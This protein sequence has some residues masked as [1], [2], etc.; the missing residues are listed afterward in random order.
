MV[1]SKVFVPVGAAGGRGTWPI[2]K[3]TNLSG[4]FLSIK[5]YTI[6]LVF[7]YGIGHLAALGLIVSL[8]FQ[9]GYEIVTVVKLE[10]RVRY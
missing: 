5:K 7:V 1:S 9:P 4:W 3:N 8:P 2:L 10:G 6:P